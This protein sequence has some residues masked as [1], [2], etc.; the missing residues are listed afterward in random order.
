V[1]PTVVDAAAD[2]LGSLREGA[3]RDPKGLWR[4]L[5]IV[6]C[7][8]VLSSLIYLLSTRA[9]TEDRYTNTMADHDKETQRDRDREQTESIIEMK[10]TL[11][12][13]DQRTERIEKRQD[14]K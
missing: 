9:V 2:G 3:V 13:I 7:V 11:K 1:T 4:F 8:A 14:A 6:G 5:T 12:A 10:A